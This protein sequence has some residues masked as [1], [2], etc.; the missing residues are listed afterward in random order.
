MV[1]KG[2]LVGM[3]TFAKKLLKGDYSEDDV[4]LLRTIAYQASVAIENAELYEDVV[5]SR[6]REGRIRNIF[7]R[8]VPK[9]V[10]DEVLKRKDDSMLAGEEREVTI[11]LADI[12][13]YTSITERLSPEQ[14]VWMLNEFFAE[15]IDV[16]FE[17]GGVVDKFMGD[18]IMAFFGAPVSYGDDCKRAVMVGLEMVERLDQLNRRR[19]ERGE[20]E[21]KIGIGIS[22]GRVVAGNIGSDKRMEYTVIG[23]D[24]NLTSRI[25]ELTKEY[26][27]GILISQSTYDQ[28]KDFVKVEKLKP[29]KVK[30]KAAPVQIYRVKGRTE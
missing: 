23:D 25:E 9:E 19:L 6:N 10:V 7:Q 8:Y 29:V 17:H 16:V 12:R 21:I 13:G 22:T 5:E 24:V 1:G 28:A 4:N 27:N 20:E 2:G 30:G 15:M 18:A 11:L 3:M 26:P 14:V